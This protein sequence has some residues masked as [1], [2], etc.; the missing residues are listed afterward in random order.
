MA[1]M[2]EAGEKVP[3]VRNYFHLYGKLEE[4]MQKTGW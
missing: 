3:N 1:S 2:V 4:L